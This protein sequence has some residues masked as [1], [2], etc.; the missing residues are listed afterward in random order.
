LVLVALVYAQAALAKPPRLFAEAHTD[1]ATLAYQHG[2]P[3]AVLSG[4]S[5]ELG[6]EHA[7]LLAAPAKGVLKF[8]KKLV[9]AIGLEPV[10]PL[11]VGA[12]RMLMLNAPERYRQEMASICAHSDLDPG[13]MA[14]GNTMLELRRM[15]C[16]TLVVQ[17]EKSAT[18][19]PL[20]GRNFDFPTLGELDK[21]SLVIVYRPEGRH[22]FASVTFPGA[23]GV[24]SGMNDAGLAV[25]TLDVMRSADGSRKFDPTGTPMALVFRRILEECTTVA[26]AEKLLH[27]IRAT[28]WTNLAVCDRDAG[29]V[30]EITP[31]HVNRRDAH[32]GVL[33]CT[34]HFRT[35]GLAQ[36]TDCWRFP[37]LASA[38]KEA[39]LDV[40]AVRQHLHQVNQGDKTLQTMVFEPR[41]LVL[42]LALG[43]PPTTDDELVAIDL[44]PLFAGA[45]QAPAAAG[46]Q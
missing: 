45:Q 12:G 39:K 24:V 11:M 35:D 41:A 20:F 10:W 15:G 31:Q 2:I 4:T 25:A 38:E 42:H 40:D 26:E 19:G 21:Y 28:T 37:L 36:G 33:P 3:I 9:A 13:E 43:S 18:G 32:D 16:S 23:I 30:F 5:D 22:A 14:V 1:G 44:R 17:P 7:E 8:P 34:N 6:R 46:G 27:S 29:A